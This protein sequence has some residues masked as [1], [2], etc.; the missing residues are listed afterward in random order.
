[1]GQV[2]AKEVDLIMAAATPTTAP[3]PG[4]ELP[5]SNED[6]GKFMDKKIPMPNVA[7]TDRGLDPQDIDQLG[8]LADL[9]LKSGMVPESILKTAR[10]EKEA[11]ARVGLI[12]EHARVLKIPNSQALQGMC[13]VRNVICIWGD[14]MQALAVR[15]PDYA[16]MSVEYVG[17]ADK[18]TCNVTIRRMIKGVTDSY[19]A[20]FSLEEAKQAG[21]AGKD[22]WKSYTKDM[23]RNRARSRAIRFMFP[24]ALCGMA[25]AEE[26][27]DAD[28]TANT[29]KAQEAAATIDSLK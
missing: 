9:Y 11:K 5:K 18:L 20:S 27:T 25:S 22:V 10:D 28:I 6:L 16:G 19:T 4:A 8:R 26:M 7:M 24:D 23:L 12:L 17:T 14:L 1:M 3:V 2:S 13:I 15:H 29:L 21:L